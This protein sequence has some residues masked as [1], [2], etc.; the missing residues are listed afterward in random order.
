MSSGGGMTLESLNRSTEE[1]GRDE[2]NL[3]RRTDAR[4]GTRDVP[5]EQMTDGH[6]TT[7]R[8][9]ATYER[10]ESGTAGVGCLTCPD[11]SRTQQSC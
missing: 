5:G 3:W 6:R 7:T 10:A 4:Y 8:H 11:K 2:H 9:E 1:M